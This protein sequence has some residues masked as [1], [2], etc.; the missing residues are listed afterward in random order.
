VVRVC[1]HDAAGTSVRRHERHRQITAAAVLVLAA[2]SAL[3]AVSRPLRDRLSWLLEVLPF[4]V[5]HVAA[6]T[7]VFLAFGLAATA[8]GLRRGHRLAWT[9]ALV[10]LGVAVVLHLVKGLDVEEGVLS[11][12]LAGWLVYARGAFTVHPSTRQIRSALLVG[13]GGTLVVLTVATTLTMTLGRVHH[14]RV[15]E[16]VRVAAER[17]GGRSTLPLALGAHSGPMLTAAGICLLTVSLWLLLGPRL[18]PRLSK[19]DHRRERERARKV[20]TRH[21]GGTL[22]YFALRDDK[23]WFLSG[24]SV[25]AYAVRHGVCLVSPDPIGPEDERAQ[26]WADFSDFA[27]RRGWAVSVIGAAESWLSLY[28]QTGL[29]ATY[30][31]DEAI[32]DCADFTLAGKANKSLR[33]AVSRV[34]RAGVS[35]TF[36]DPSSADPSVQEAVNGIVAMSRRGEQERGFSMTLS[37]LFDPADTGLLLAVASD[38]RGRTLGF[39]QWIPAAAIGGWSLDVMRRDT[40]PDVPNGIID[41]LVVRTIERINS[42]G[43]GGLGLNFAVLRETMTTEAEDARGHAVRRILKVASRY[44]QL[45]SLGT[46]NE[47]FHP[48]WVPRYVMRGYG[49]QLAVQALALAR[50]E[51]L[52]ELPT[53]WLPRA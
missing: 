34:E 22:D 32:V 20:V 7:M 37:R 51:G 3:S 42:Q 14:P 50:A 15:G 52:V 31:G 24:D 4:P 38:D 28:E 25:V 6:T 19:E 45:E 44:S 27:A 18:Q 43:G 47:K 40:S 11:C 53:V 35:V 17:L 13:G 23:T 9:A 1:A 16:S 41:T 5:L 39:I 29:K 46:F 8:R 36:H 30:L 26:V 21:G 49:D 33:Q 10:M 2:L 12:L 48:R